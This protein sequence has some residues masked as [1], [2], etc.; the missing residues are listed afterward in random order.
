[1]FRV[2]GPN[3]AEDHDDFI[4]YEI[5]HSDLEVEIIGEYDF[6]TFDKD[7]TCRHVL[8]HSRQTL[9]LPPAEDSP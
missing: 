3:H 4:D 7:P 6:Y 2:Y 9:G 5:A 1:V 8:D